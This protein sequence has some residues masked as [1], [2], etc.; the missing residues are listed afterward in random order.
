MPVGQMRRHKGQTGRRGQQVQLKWPGAA[1][2]VSAPQKP[3]HRRKQNGKARDPPGIGVHRAGASQTVIYDIQPPVLP[4]VAAENQ[5]VDVV[6]QPEGQ[7]GMPGVGVDGGFGQHQ[8]I[9]G[10]HHLEPAARCG[11]PVLHRNRI[12]AGVDGLGVQALADHFPGKGGGI[13]A[14][15][16]LRVGRGIALLRRGGPVAVPSPQAPHGDRRQTQ[17]G[18]GQQQPVFGTLH[19]ITSLATVYHTCTDNCNRV[20]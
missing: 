20:Y 4:G 16:C 10:I 9:H 6:V 7:I 1:C 15:S 3:A 13:S 2:A 17:H 14:G 18:R 11:V 12:L 5:L 19:G 8:I